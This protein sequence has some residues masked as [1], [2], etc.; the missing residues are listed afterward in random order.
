M[1]TD[2]ASEPNRYVFPSESKVEV[3]VTAS[4]NVGIC[5]SDNSWGQENQT[6]VISRGRL[7][8]FIAWLQEIQTDLDAGEYDDDPQPTEV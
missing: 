6:N 5:E 4:C 7:P 2:T 8:Q 1:T 3:Y